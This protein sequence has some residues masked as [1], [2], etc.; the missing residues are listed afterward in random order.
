MEHMTNIESKPNTHALGRS[1][2][3]KQVVGLFLIWMNSLSSGTDIK[4]LNDMWFVRNVSE[5]W[6]RFVDTIMLKLVK[7][8]AVGNIEDNEGTP[9]TV[10]VRNLGRV[11]IFDTCPLP[12][13]R[14]EM[15]LHIPAI[16]DDV[17]TFNIWTRLLSQR[18][19]TEVLKILGG[20]RLVSKTW[21][22]SVDTNIC[23]LVELLAVGGNIKDKEGTPDMVLVRNLG[24]V[25]ILDTCPLPTET[26]LHI[27]AIPDDV[28]TFN[29]WTKLLSQGNDTEVLKILRGARRVSKTWRRSVHTNLCNLVELLAVGGNIKDNEGTPDTVLVRNLGKVAT[30]FY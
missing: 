28:F 7:L 14:A 6:E 2:F 9:D 10:L 23:N 29:I 16:S 17:F 20:S 1:F 4:V 15:P 21:R 12:L 24:K 8:L 19:D 26:P 5:T 22:R 27:P 13:T 18:N 11:A 25:A 3:T 30:F